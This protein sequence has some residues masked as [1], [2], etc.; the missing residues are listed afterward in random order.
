MQFRWS[1]VQMLD[2]HGR[3]CCVV[4]EEY[5]V[6]TEAIQAR[7]SFYNS[8]LRLIDWISDLF[9]I[10]DSIRNVFQDREKWREELELKNIFLSEIKDIY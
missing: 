7:Q 6:E 10:S 4:S 9:T 5:K 1:V 8:F 3:L 2:F